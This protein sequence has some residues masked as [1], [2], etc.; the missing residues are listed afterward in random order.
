MADNKIRIDVA[1]NSKNAE[2]NAKNLSKALDEVK[3][4]MEQTAKTDLNIEIGRAHV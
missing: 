4:T 2:Q 1:F 3:S